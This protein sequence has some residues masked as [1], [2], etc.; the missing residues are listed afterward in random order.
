VAD[1]IKG[2]EGLHTISA[3]KEISDGV[4]FIK[5]QPAHLA[6]A[7][8]FCGLG[9]SNRFLNGEHPGNP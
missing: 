3:R 1:K 6:K 9:I 7:N 2:T 4:L 5:F 8:E